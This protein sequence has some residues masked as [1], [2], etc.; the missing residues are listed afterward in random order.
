MTDFCALFVA[1][2]KCSIRNILFVTF[3]Q[4]RSQSRDAHCMLL[5]HK[6][7]ATIGFR[8][9]CVKLPSWLSTE[10]FLTAGTVQ[11]K[12]YKKSNLRSRHSGLRQSKKFSTFMSNN[13]NIILRI[14]SK[15]RNN[16]NCI[17]RIGST[18]TQRV[19]VMHCFGT[20]KYED[21]NLLKF[22][23]WLVK[24]NCKTDVSWNLTWTTN[25]WDHHNYTC[26]FAHPVA[27]EVTTI[28]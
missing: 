15:T 6:W 5:M 27:P 10:Y 21:R 28:N 18:V 11:Y 14:R 12:R 23:D 8:V 17:Q 26:I 20:F 25:S 2:R 24:I 19:Y 4:E 22:L 7:K 1:S 9:H 16:I 13:G 3:R